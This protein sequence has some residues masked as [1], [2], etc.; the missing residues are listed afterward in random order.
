MQWCQCVTVQAAGNVE[1]VQLRESTVFATDY[2]SVQGLRD[3]RMHYLHH[4]TA[5]RK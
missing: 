1:L 2:N 3:H 5:L 4:H